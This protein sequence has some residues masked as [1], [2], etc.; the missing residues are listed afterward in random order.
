MLPLIFFTFHEGATLSS[1]STA[2]HV[3]VVPGMLS[4]PLAFQ[5]APAPNSNHMLGRHCY[6]MQKDSVIIATVQ[7]GAN[8][9]KHTSE[10]WFVPACVHAESLQPCPALW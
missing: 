9:P 4:H 5:Q 3:P 10:V 7:S 8:F 6:W 1:Q 2:Q